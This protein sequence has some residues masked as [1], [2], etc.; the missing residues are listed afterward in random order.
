EGGLRAR[1]EDDLE[2]KTTK[3]LGLAGLPLV[4]KLRGHKILK[5]LMV[6]SDLK[7][8]QALELRALFLERFYDRE[9]FLIVDLVVALLGG[10]FRR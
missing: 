2:V 8:R 7:L 5:V 10:V 9:E 1:L 3:E 6:G 4:K